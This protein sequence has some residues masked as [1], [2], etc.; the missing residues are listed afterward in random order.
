M[1]IEPCPRLSIEVED[2]AVYRLSASW[3][4]ITN[5]FYEPI[6]HG[7]TFAATGG[8]ELATDRFA[9]GGMA[10]LQSQLELSDGLFVPQA[11]SRAPMVL[12]HDAEACFGR[13]EPPRRMSLKASRLCPQSE[14]GIRHRDTS[15]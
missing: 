13:A 5:D 1:Q 6:E 7:L 8:F 11:F 2:D 15:A 12:P 4:V 9:S 14:S 10:P 3:P